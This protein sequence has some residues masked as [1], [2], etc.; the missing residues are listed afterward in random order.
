[1]N[2][3]LWTLQGS[4][5]L[6]FRILAETVYRRV[7]LME[8][9]LDAPLFDVTPRVPAEISI[10]A[11]AEV[12]AYLALRTDLDPAEV[13]RRLLAGAQCFAVRCR[14]RLVHAGW[15]TTRDARVDYLG[16]PFPLAPG[17][18]YQF[19]SFTDP[20]FRRLNL[21]AARITWMAR[22]FLDAGQRRLIAVVVPE[23]VHA[24]RPLEKTGYRP[25]GWMA[26]VRLGRW[27]RIVYA[28]RG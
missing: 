26:V 17:E 28:R 7:V 16:C 19:G 2:R 20:E 25:C 11:P 13:N 3:G 22:H 6:W 10:L 5:A 27:R 21:A 15:A 24:F 14:G 23:N 18:V 1:M 9:G 12:E 4:R 8:R